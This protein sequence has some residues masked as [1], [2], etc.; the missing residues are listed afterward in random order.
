MFQ[1][2]DIFQKAAEEY[3]KSLKWHDETPDFA[4]TLVAGNIRNFATIIREKLK[5]HKDVA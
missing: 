5:D 1:D 2:T 4:R 3:I